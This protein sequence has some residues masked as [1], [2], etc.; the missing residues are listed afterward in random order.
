[1][2]LSLASDVK[3]T[4]RLGSPCLTPGDRLNV[5]I[6]RGA[7]LCL[8][9]CLPHSLSQGTR[10][11]NSLERV[12]VGHQLLPSGLSPPLQ[13]GDLLKPSQRM[14]RTQAG[15]LIM[16][17]ASFASDFNIN[18]TEDS[19]VNLTLALA[20]QLG[21]GNG[22]TGHPQGRG[23]WTLA[24]HSH[25]RLGSRGT[26]DGLHGSNRAWPRVLAHTPQRPGG[27]G[28]SLHTLTPC[29]DPVVPLMAWHCQ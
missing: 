11:L 26:E 2:G 7:D 10:P 15:F 13:G 5:W 19:Y 23:A 16:K 4:R 12:W 27:M 20:F 6:M 17:Y 24:C 21:G 8:E 22:Q 29:S 28:T 25:T 14:D 9:P 1:M 18:Q 3:C